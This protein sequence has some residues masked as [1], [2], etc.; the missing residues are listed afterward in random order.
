MSSLTFS[1]GTPLINVGLRF[2]RHPY[3]NVF[4]NAGTV[5]L[6]VASAV[7]EERRVF[8]LARTTSK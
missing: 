6:C 8:L 4:E 3:I 2:T 7:V 5:T 1:S